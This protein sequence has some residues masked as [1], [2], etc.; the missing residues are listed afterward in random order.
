MAYLSRMEREAVTRS[1]R[2]HQRGLEIVAVA[3]EGG[4]TFRGAMSTPGG[5]GGER[6]G[7]PLCVTFQRCHRFCLSFRDH[8]HA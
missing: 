1:V 5:E 8:P 2:R 3:K 7:G 4:T 6:Q